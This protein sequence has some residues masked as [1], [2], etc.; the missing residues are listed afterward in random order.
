MADNEWLKQMSMMYFVRLNFPKYKPKTIIKH[1]KGDI[2]HF[3][4]MYEAENKEDF[5]IMYTMLEDY[6]STGKT[7]TLMRMYEGGY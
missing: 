7:E 1:L 4:R 5:K 6:L 3:K 2:R